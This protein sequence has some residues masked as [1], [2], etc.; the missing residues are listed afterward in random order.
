MVKM[1][2]KF[3]RIPVHEDTYEQIRKLGTCGDSFDDVLKRIL[4][5]QIG[6]CKINV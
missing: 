5:K 6:V 4:S 3:K 2:T 1:L